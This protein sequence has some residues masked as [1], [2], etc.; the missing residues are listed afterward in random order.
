[1]KTREQLL[2]EYED[3]YFALLM[4]EVAASEGRKALELERQLQEDPD[5][6][7]PPDLDRKCLAAIRRE[8]AA[9]RRRAMGRTARKVLTRVCTAAGIAAFL[10]LGAFAASEEV[11]AGTLNL[12]METMTDRTQFY[13]GD[14]PADTVPQIDLGWVP[15]GF[16]LAD[17]GVTSNSSWCEYRKEESYIRALYFPGNGM[18][19]SV[20]SEAADARPV[21]ISPAVTAKMFYKDGELQIAWGTPDQ[22]AFLS[23]VCQGITEEELLHAA[24]ELRY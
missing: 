24:Q 14:K 19:L 10:F 2:E 8:F 21:Q 9:K 6:E 4:N 15:D 13:F 11:R 5:A 20:D 18:L 16:T 1:M 7:V 3:A 23:V 12:V 17:S 22:T